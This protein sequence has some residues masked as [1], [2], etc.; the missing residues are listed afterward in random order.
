M[1]VAAATVLAAGWTA[2]AAS[3]AAAVVNAS[4]DANG[5]TFTVTAPGVLALRA[6]FSATVVMDGQ[7]QELSS[8]AG[9]VVTPPVPATEATPY[10]QAEVTE[11]A[12]RFNLKFQ[13]F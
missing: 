3:P 12:I 11:T 1:A 2:G 4:L 6:G 9:T 8:A 13:R 5:R 7:R 10:G